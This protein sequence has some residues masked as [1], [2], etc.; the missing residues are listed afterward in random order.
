M[1]EFSG[2]QVRKFFEN[3]VPARWRGGVPIVPVVRL[4]RSDRLFDPVAA[5]D[6]D[7]GSGAPAGTGFSYKH[8]KAVALI[9][10]SPGGSPVQSTWSI[11]ASGDWRTRR[12]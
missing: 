8:A 11:A 7:F 9:V 5:G 10:N 4:Y 3:L 1:A 6:H 2:E 12:S